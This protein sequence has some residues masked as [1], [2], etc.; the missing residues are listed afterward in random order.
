MNT[1]RKVQLTNYIYPSPEQSCTTEA[2]A[3]LQNPEISVPLN[4]HAKQG[5]ATGLSV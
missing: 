4:S 3:K 2:Q 1:V 5:F